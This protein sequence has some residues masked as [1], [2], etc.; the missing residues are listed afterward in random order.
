MNRIQTTT[1]ADVEQQR[2]SKDGKAFECDFREGSNRFER[3]GSEPAAYYVCDDVGHYQYKFPRN[4][5][6]EG[7][8]RKE[9]DKINKVTNRNQSKVTTSA[10]TLETVALFITRWWMQNFKKPT[11]R[12]CNIEPINRIALYCKKNENQ[13]NFYRIKKQASSVKTFLNGRIQLINKDTVI[14]VA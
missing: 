12:L 2:K 6:I 7:K 1:W 3:K 4:T 10:A 14:A 9:W 11:V 8:K 13:R 5:A